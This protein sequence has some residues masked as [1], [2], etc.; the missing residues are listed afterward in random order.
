MRR[1]VLAAVEHLTLLVVCNRRA[2]APAAGDGHGGNAAF[3]HLCYDLEFTVPLG[4]ER[5]VVTS[6][7][8]RAP[9]RVALPVACV[10][11]RRVQNTHTVRTAAPAP[12][13]GIALPA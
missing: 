9:V 10:A 5:M 2:C 7:S 12:L 13:A 1:A 6:L 11:V 8:T 3:N 4:Y